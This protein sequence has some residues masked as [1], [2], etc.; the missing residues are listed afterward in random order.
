MLQFRFAVVFSLTLALF[1][2]TALVSAP[3][4]VVPS[5]PRLL[6]VDRLGDCPGPASP[7]EQIYVG[8]RVAFDLDGRRQ[9]T[10]GLRFLA[11]DGTPALSIV[12]DRTSHS[13][14]ISDQGALT[15]RDRVT[16]VEDPLGRFESSVRAVT[17]ATLGR[18][19]TRSS[20]SSIRLGATLRITVTDADG[21]SLAA[22]ITLTNLD[23][24]RA[25]V[26]TQGNA[27]QGAVFYHIDPAQPVY[28]TITAEGY[29][30]GEVA[31]DADALAPGSIS[32][33]TVALKKVPPPGPQW[34]P[35]QLRSVLSSGDTTRPVVYL[36]FD[37]GVGNVRLIASIL[38]TYGVRA[39]FCSYGAALAADTAIIAELKAAGHVFCNHTWSHGDIRAMSAERIA[40]ELASTENVVQANG[41]GT[42]KPF[43][44][45]PGD[46]WDARTVEIVAQQGY[47]TIRWTVDPR[48]WACETNAAGLADRVLSRIGYGSIVILHPFGCA[49]AAAL[50]AIIEGLQARGYS[51]ETFADLPSWK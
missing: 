9:L 21:A 13:R 36:T 35:T 31:I 26:Q 12:P 48:D 50:P 41:G 4:R 33:R 23:C 8:S 3:A 1:P 28:A 17:F 19:T 29:L 46:W 49:T 16:V 20:P 11:A 34:S 18:R 43:F 15:R 32:E 27:I 7:G 24:T 40:S 37:N 6:R 5:A 42:T 14:P 39:T 25:P 30:E 45:P 2:A 38:A 22:Q 51:F 44:R 10:W 47:R